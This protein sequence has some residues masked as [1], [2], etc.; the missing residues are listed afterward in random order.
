[1]HLIIHPVSLIWVLVS[2]S[3]L[4]EMK[5]LIFSIVSILFFVT[6][7]SAAADFYPE[8]LAARMVKIALKEKDV[9]L[10]KKVELAEFS[11]K[12]EPVVVYLFDRKEGESFYAV[13]TQAKGRYENF[14]YLLAVNEKFTIEKVRVLKYRSEHG[15]EIASRKWLTQFEDYASG[16]LRYKKEISA[17]SGATISANSIV[18][19]IPKVLKILKGSCN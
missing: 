17:L 7:Q 8:K 10:V 3:N 16:E 18:A 6:L 5:T 13:F 19:D 11:G 14:D 12:R 2:G 1:M 9:T 4:R 15:G